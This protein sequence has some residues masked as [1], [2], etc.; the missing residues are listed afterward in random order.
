MCVRSITQLMLIMLTAAVIG[1]DAT[2]PTAPAKSRGPS[3][4]AVGEEH[5]DVGV[6]AR[7]SRPLWGSFADIQFNWFVSHFAEAACGGGLIA[8]TEAQATGHVTNLG[9]TNAV[10]SA[11]WD[12]SVAAAG[13]YSPSGPSTG[14][15]ATV[16][17][18][19][20]H[21][22]CSSPEIAT[23]DPVLTVANGDEV[24]GKVSGGEVYELGFNVPG[25]GQEQFIEVEITGGTGRFR[26]ASGFF[27]IHAIVDLAAGEPTVIEILPGGTIS[28]SPA[29]VPGNDL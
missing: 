27:V 25:D 6:P 20:P 4:V 29:R 17:D 12:W 22:F 14:T 10:A 1:C 5:L 16:L 7:P 2:I 26:N 23:G 19:Y 3:S 28:Y 13:V 18:T 21:A 8:G 9:R 11:A 15:S 24:H